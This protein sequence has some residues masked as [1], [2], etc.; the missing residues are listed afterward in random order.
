MQGWTNSLVICVVLLVLGWPTA[1]AAAPLRTG[2]GGRLDFGAN[3]L[4][5][6]TDMEDVSTPLLDLS[7]DFPSGLNFLGTTYSALYLNSNGNLTFDRPTDIHT[8]LPFP[9]VG[10]IMVAPWWGD[11]AV[12]ISPDPMRGV[13]WDIRSGEFTA[14]WYN[15]PYWS[16]TPA[17]VDKHDSF[18]VIISDRSDVGLPGDFDLELRYEQCEWTTG[19]LSGGMDGL[20][21]DGAQVGWNVGDGID[22]F[23]LPGSGTMDVLQLCDTSNVGDPGVWVYQFRNGCVVE[24]GLEGCLPEAIVYGTGV[25]CNV[26]TVPSASPLPW[27]ALGVTLLGLGLRRRGRR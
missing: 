9:R 10:L 6:T 11:V 14:T 19:D 22:G 3:E 15:V 16:R 21:G 2:L 20:G 26:A 7:G 13:F 12:D 23:V 1:T 25:A 24:L 8:P 17:L 5:S 4:L 18:Q 27:A